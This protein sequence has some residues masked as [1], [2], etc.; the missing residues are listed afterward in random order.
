MNQNR[1]SSAVGARKGYSMQINDGQL[2]YDGT[3]QSKW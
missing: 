2:D 1:N 3:S